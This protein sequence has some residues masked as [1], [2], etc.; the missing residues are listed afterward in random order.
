MD[1]ITIR[2]PDDFHVHLREDKMLQNVFPFTFLAFER[3]LAMGNL[4]KPIVSG[5]DARRY[6]KKIISLL[7][8]PSIF[9][10]I[11]SIMMVNGITPD[12]VSHACPA[13]ALVLKLIPGGASTN[14]D[15]GV[16]L[17]K[18]RKYYSVLKVAEKQGAIFSIHAELN[19]DLNGKEVPELEREEKAIPYIAQIIKDFPELK[20]VVE[21][22]STKKMVEFIISSPPNVAATITAHHVILTYDDVYSNGKIIDPFSYCKPVAKLENDR[23]AVLGAMLSNNLKFFFGSDSAPHLLDK[24]FKNPPAAGIFSAP[25][26]LPI[27]A[28]IFEKHGALERLEN[29]VSYFGAKFY[30]LPLNQGEITLIKKPWIVPAI[31]NNIPVFMGDKTLDWQIKTK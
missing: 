29:F 26:A 14:S 31:I 4:P 6:R 27:L 18:L 15:D 11:T 23:R 22:V 8:P 30:E 12:I 25:V 28:Q 2:A 20:I 16:S 17:I 13:D 9:K 1:S 3:C 21:H 19:F 10:L 7:P 5:I 24:K